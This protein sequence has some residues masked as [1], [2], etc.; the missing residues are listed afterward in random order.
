[1]ISEETLN[2]E[3]V[4]VK[5][6]LKRLIKQGRLPEALENYHALQTLEF[7]RDWEDD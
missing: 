2:D 6:E 3:I 7:V 5:K 4:M 1:M